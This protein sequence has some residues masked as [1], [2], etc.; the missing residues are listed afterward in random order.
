MSIQ[1]SRKIG[2]IILSN[3]GIPESLYKRSLELI[4]LQESIRLELGSPLSEHLYLANFCKDTIV[5]FTDS[6]AWA[7]KLRF[8]TNRIIEIARNQPKLQQLQTVRIRTSPMLLA[9]TRKGDSVSIS[10]AATRLLEEVAQ[11][12]DDPELRHSLL[13]LS[14]NKRD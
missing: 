13:R 9:E 5:I 1:H 3:K 7:A 12:M 6:P 14:Q 2:D 11:N 10:P 8:K 4:K